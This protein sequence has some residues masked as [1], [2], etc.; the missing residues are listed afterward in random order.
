MLL[1][2]PHTLAINAFALLWSSEMQHVGLQAN[3]AILDITYRK[4]LRLNLSA[5][6]LH[7]A[8]PLIQLL[9]PD[10]QQFVEGLCHFHNAWA[11]PMRVG[12]S[13]MLLFMFLGQFFTRLLS[14]SQL[15]RQLQRTFSLERSVEIIESSG[16]STPH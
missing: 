7:R 2:S 4:V 6:T 1:P 5:H 11:V 14:H 15:D 13:I 16:S 9:L 8:S 3:G 10:A 12:G